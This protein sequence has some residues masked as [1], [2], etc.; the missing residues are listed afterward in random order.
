M[1]PPRRNQT[2]KTPDT[3]PNPPLIRTVYITLDIMV[4]TY[5]AVTNKKKR[6]SLFYAAR[7]STRHNGTLR[8]LF[9]RGPQ[10][11]TFYLL[12]DRK[13]PHQIFIFNPY[14]TIIIYNSSVHTRRVKCLRVLLFGD[15]ILY[16]K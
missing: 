5:T 11:I 7:P 8:D 16:E 2:E 1:H 13:H 12:I 3:I 14:N 6:C 10:K 15:R 4:Y 9:R